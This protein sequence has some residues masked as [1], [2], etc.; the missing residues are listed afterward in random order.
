MIDRLLADARDHARR[1]A[2]KLVVEAAIEGE[3]F[4]L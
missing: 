3:G 1:L 4:S 2:P